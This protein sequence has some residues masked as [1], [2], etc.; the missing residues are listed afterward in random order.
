MTAKWF[1]AFVRTNTLALALMA[2]TVCGFG[3]TTARADGGVAPDHAPVSGNLASLQHGAQLYATYCMSCHSASFVHYDQW[4]A[5]GFTPQQ[6]QA[7]LPAG[8]SMS[9]ALTSALRADDAKAA[10]GA[11]PP[12]L[13]LEARARSEDWLYMYLRSF[14][15]DSARPGGW[16]N[17]M[18]ENTAMPHILAALQGIRTAKFVDE[19][20]AKTGQ[21]VRRFAGYQQVTPGTLSPA[22]YDAAVADL[23]A[24]LSWMAGP[25]Q[26]T[27]QQLGAG[28]LVFLCVLSFLA[29]R[30]HAAYW[31]QIE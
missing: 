11:V 29:W 16:N 26:K 23:V 3:A 17:R 4:R 30:L 21:P 1:L 18:A 24:Y 25:E 10:Y 22:G 20:D 13:S 9:D 27:R 19:T 12:D 14:Y 2:L 7:M 5:L 15:Q 31:K 6:I 28:V 8:A